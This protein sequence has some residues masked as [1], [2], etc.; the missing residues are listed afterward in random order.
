MA[1]SCRNGAAAP[2]L[3][4]LKLHLRPQ[5]NRPRPASDFPCRLR[6]GE[7]GPSRP[8]ARSLHIAMVSDAARISWLE[9]RTDHASATSHA[10]TVTDDE[11][12]RQALL[13]YSAMV[14]AREAPR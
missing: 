14:R 5:L 4:I 12:V 2:S 6:S 9:M 8:G 10:L 3:L 11:N 1:A 7:T 13:E